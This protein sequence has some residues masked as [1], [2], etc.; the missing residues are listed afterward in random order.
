MNAREEFWKGSFG[1][2]YNRRSP[3]DEEANFRLFKRALFGFQ[4]S[5]IVEL[6]AGTGA[7]L[8]AL[9]RLRPGAELAGVEINPEAC[10]AL[11]SS[12]AVAHGMLRVINESI[13]DWRPEHRWEL[14]FTKGVL[15]HIAPEDLAKA[16]AALFA[17]SAR[18]ILV[19]EYYSPK[20]VEI[21]YR[22]HAGRLWK[23]DFAGDLLDTFPNLRL[24]DYGFVYR[25]DAHP[26]DDL[27]WFLME[28][29][30]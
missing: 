20:P 13:L 8:R 11:E 7:N 25:R 1:N 10:R 19:A 5:S 9:H 30:Q 26:Q 12:P 2:E 4:L 3:G 17:A 21:D 6:G 22:G 28:K 29:T 18:Y 23:R 15:I 27:T 14:A 16:Y 24:V